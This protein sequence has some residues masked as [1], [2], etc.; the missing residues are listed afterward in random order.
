MSLFIRSVAFKMPVT[1]RSLFQA[2]KLA[3]K[4]PVFFSPRYKTPVLLQRVPDDLIWQCG[5]A[6][7]R[8]SSHGNRPELS[9][10]CRCQGESAQQPT[11]WSR[12]STNVSFPSRVL[13]LLFYFL[14]NIHP[15]ESNH[16][17]V[18]RCKSF[19]LYHREMSSQRGS[20]TEWTSLSQLWR[21]SI[22]QHSALLCL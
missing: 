14:L 22:L 4:P 1:R 12:H 7:T 6:T 21:S 18:G 3:R 8:S 2:R 19:L 17:C 9:D 20:L 10:F 15:F 16:P 5:G 13:F 11:A